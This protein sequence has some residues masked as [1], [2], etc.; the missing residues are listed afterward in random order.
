MFRSDTAV[1]A[2][3]APLDSNLRAAIENAAREWLAAGPGAAEL[4]AHVP[5][6]HLAFEAYINNRDAGLWNL[7]QASI[8]RVNE[9]LDPGTMPLEHLAALTGLNLRVWQ[10]TDAGAYRDA[11]SRLTL[12]MIARFDNER[13][14]F[15]PNATDAP[16]L[17]CVSENARVAEVLYRAWRALDA[18]GARPVAGTVLGNV[19]DA[20]VPGEGL[21]QHVEMPGG[22]RS[23]AQ[24][25]PAYANAVRM[26]LTATQTT[27]RGTYVSRASILADFIL[28]QAWADP[29]QLA[30]DERA[31]LADAYAR[32][33]SFTH[34][35]AYRDRAYGMLRET[36]DV[37][38]SVNAASYALAMEHSGSIV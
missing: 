18:A 12:E 35:E 7:L 11:A 15:H 25:A 16:S 26:F 23:D 27:G 28:A 13:E 38:L 36:G 5:A 34:A 1:L 33:Y 29:S 32:L 24:S 14:M 30:F 2:T 20:F 3:P 8:A 9:T 22:A 10:V 37:P 19:S 21:Y 31:A 17:F 4:A 6:L